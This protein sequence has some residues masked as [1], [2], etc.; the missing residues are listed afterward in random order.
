M[1][2]LLLDSLGNRL[3]IPGRL[4]FNHSFLS[5]LVEIRHLLQNLNVLLVAEGVPT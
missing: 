3:V 1:I 4:W 2:F 5:F